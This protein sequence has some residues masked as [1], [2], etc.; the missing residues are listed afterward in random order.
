MKALSIWQP[1]ASLLAAGVKS[2]ETR[3][4]SPPAD[5]YRTRIALHA[6]QSMVGM[7]LMDENPTFGALVDRLLG[8]D[9]PY[10]FGRIVAVASIAFVIDTDGTVGREVLPQE[11]L[12]GDWSPGR[13]A[14]R[15]TEAIALPRPVRCRGRQ[16]LWRL[17]DGVTAQVEAQL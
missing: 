12:L 4:W 14:W 6:G 3:R 10:Q 1:W 13:Y 7:Q 17:P 5:C 15:I 11:K 8:V 16:K 9:N 2:Y